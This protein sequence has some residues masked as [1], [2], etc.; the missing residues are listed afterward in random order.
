MSAIGDWTCIRTIYRNVWGV[1]K[2]ANLLLL[3]ERPDGSQ[4]WFDSEALY[5][6]DS[7]SSGD[8]GGL[9]R[10]FCLK[11]AIFAWESH[12]NHSLNRPDF[13]V[14]PLSRDYFDL[15]ALRTPLFAPSSKSEILLELVL[16]PGDGGA[17]MVLKLDQDLNLLGKCRFAF[18]PYDNVVM[19]K[20][21]TNGQWTG[22][23]SRKQSYSDSTIK[24]TFSMIRFDS[25][26]MKPVDKHLHI[27]ELSDAVEDMVIEDDGTVWFLQTELNCWRPCLSRPNELKHVDSIT[28]PFRRTTTNILINFGAQMW[29]VR[30]EFQLQTWFVEKDRSQVTQIET[31]S[32]SENKTRYS[33]GVGV[34]LPPS[35]PN[36]PVQFADCRLTLSC[37]GKRLLYSAGWANF[38]SLWE[39]KMETPGNSLRNLCCWNLI[40]T[41]SVP[42]EFALP[43]SFVAKICEDY[44]DLLL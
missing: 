8:N 44:K 1:S 17:A 27:L 31:P 32:N 21:S 39:L 29:I 22:R 25:D 40:K 30:T 43:D 7:N 13:K 16:L 5:L 37:D 2:Y 38:P 33:L 3:R 6:C 34:L 41:R 35:V 4:I 24:Y 12:D 11:C 19:S 23:I 36:L 20:W 15:A 18:H 28:L 14:T 26:T 9:I 42:G 10:K